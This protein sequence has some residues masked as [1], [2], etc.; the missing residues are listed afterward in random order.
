MHCHQW[1]KTLTDSFNNKNDGSLHLT[2]SQPCHNVPLQIMQVESLTVA[3]ILNEYFLNGIL[4]RF[5]LV[6]AH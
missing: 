2:E 6:Y 3:D 5:E 1:N 4:I